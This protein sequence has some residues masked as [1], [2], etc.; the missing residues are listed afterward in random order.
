VPDKNYHIASGGVR[1]RFSNKLSLDLSTTHEAEKNYIIY[2]GREVNGEP[3]IA[4]VDFTDITS[5]LSGIYNFT[6]RI[7]LTLRTRY[8]RSRVLYNSFANVTEDGHPVARPFIPNQDENVNIFNLDGFLT[9][10]FRLGS[11]LI[12]GY[13]NWLGDDEVID[14]TIY[15]T[16]LSNFGQLFNLPHGNEFTLKFIYFLDYNQLKKK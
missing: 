6:P 4:F 5:V 1:Y 9:W 12:L 7:N 16:Y 14:G 2:A 15:K 13:K 10:D 11:R 3:I 8:Y